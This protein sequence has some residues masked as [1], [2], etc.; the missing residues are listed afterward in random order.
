LAHVKDLPV[1]LFFNCKN[2]KR[3]DTNSQGSHKSYPEDQVRARGSQDDDFD[4]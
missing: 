1:K 3:K 4:I 2:S